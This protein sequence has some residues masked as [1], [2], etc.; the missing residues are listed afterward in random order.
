VGPS[1]R[2][3]RRL[4]SLLPIEL[5]KFFPKLRSGNYEICSKATGRY[6]CVAFVNG[7]ERHWWEPGTYGS[8][9]Y[10]PPNI[11]QRDN[12]EAWVEL[13]E[14]QGYELTNNHDIES[15]VEKVALYVSFKD[16]LPSHVARSDGRIWKSKLGKGQDIEHVSLDVL[17]GEQQHEYGIV[18]RV[19]KKVTRD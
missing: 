8:R 10:W 1:G 6:N 2:N 15:G 7:D 4:R 5:E 14:K 9:F 12:L 11:S 17:E 3:Y 19:L 13:F 16:M 18:E